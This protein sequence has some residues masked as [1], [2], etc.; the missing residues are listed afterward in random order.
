MSKNYPAIEKDL[1]E[2]LR[3]LHQAD[4]EVMKA[5]AKVSMEAKRTEVL[6]TRTKE[7][8]C[9]AIGIAVHCDGCIA[10]HIAGAIQNSATR[11]EIA[12]TVM[13]AILMGGGPSV[14][15]GADA[16]KAFDQF[17]AENAGA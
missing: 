11:E 5:F 1:N 9:L 12:E 16:L 17:S 4:P 8:M 10:H 6:D 3:H 13:V 7:L 2:G 15:Y 14:F